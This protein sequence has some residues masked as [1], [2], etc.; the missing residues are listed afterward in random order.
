[1]GWQPPQIYHVAC[2][3]TLLFAG[4]TTF[5]QRIFVFW[6]QYVL[7]NFHMPV[8]LKFLNHVFGIH[9]VKLDCYL[10]SKKIHHRGKIFV[11]QRL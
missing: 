8:I 7:L 2:C 1:M 3:R 11:R 10:L 9:S 4:Y 5:D 6:I